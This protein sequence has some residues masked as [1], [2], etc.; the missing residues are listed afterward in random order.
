MK[1][2]L[3]RIQYFDPPPFPGKVYYNSRRIPLANEI[4]SMNILSSPLIQDTNI[5]SQSLSIDDTL[6]NLILPRTFTLVLR[7]GILKAINPSNLVLQIYSCK[8]N[9][10]NFIANEILVYEFPPPPKISFICLTH[11]LQQK[12]LFRKFSNPSRKSVLICHDFVRRKKVIVTK[13]TAECNSHL[14]DG[15][16]ICR[17][18]EQSTQQGGIATLQFP[19]QKFLCRRWKVKEGGLNEFDMTCILLVCR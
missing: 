15:T 18:S 11:L 16:L 9:R 1:F 3:L 4:Q 8:N 2:W 12:K 17:C 5:E 14:C 7:F 19:F 10:Y 13:N 6:R